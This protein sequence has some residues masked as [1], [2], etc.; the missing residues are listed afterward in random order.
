MFA[1]FGFDGVDFPRQKIYTLGWALASFRRYARLS[2]I[3]DAFDYKKGSLHCE[4]VC[5]SDIVRQVGTPVYVYSARTL[6]EHYR[7]LAEAFAPLDAT[8]CFAVKSLSNV[9]VLRLLAE[10]GCGFDIVSMGELDRVSRARGEMSKVVFAG[11][12]KT[13]AEIREAIW[14]GIAMFNVE[15]EAEFQNISRLAAEVKKPVR[16]ALRINPDVY[17]PKTHQYTTTG[18][19]ETKFGVDIDRAGAFF[20]ACQNDPYVTLDAIHLH[21]GSPI[22]S[23]EPYVQAITKTLGFMEELEAKG[24]LIRALNIGGGYAADYEEGK[25]PTAQDYAAAIVP[26]LKDRGLEIYLEPGRQI[27][28]NA[29]ILLSKVLYTK[30]GGEKKFAIVDAAMTDLLR[31]ALY[32]AEHFVYPTEL[33]S[34]LDAPP[35]KLGYQPKDGEVVDVVGGVCE[36]SDTLAADRCLPPLE[37]GTLLAIF[38]AGAYGFVMSSQYNSRPRPAE[39]L[40]DGKTWRVIRRRETYDDLIAAERDME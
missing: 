16:C 35:R 27:A 24:I 21:I 23:P 39:V 22:Y 1:G 33:A 11:V 3:M 30:Q 17:D 5:V 29:G 36:T 37:R 14:K 12:G 25:S 8:I 40:V 7:A 13:D 2:R 10:E 9:H 31:P 4:Q 19:K 34:D 38:S 28:C 26:L 18:K 32:Q 20:T 15:S 6:R